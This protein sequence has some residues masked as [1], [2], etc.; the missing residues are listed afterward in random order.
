ML[1]EMEEVQ[2]SWRVFLL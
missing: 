2:T 1:A